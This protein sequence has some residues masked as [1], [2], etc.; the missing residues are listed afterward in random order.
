MKRNY[1]Y[2]GRTSL[3]LQNTTQNPTGLR[4]G[5]KRLETPRLANNQSELTNERLSTRPGQATLNEA[6]WLRIN[7]FAFDSENTYVAR[8]QGCT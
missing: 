3:Q 8:R 5:R 4:Q 7:E 1:L 6:V 2:H